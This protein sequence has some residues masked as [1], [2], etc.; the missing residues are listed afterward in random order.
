M[1][2]RKQLPP[3]VELWRDR[4]GKLRAYFRKDRGTRIALPL[5]IGSPE[6]DVAYREALVGGPLV[7]AE[8]IR[9]RGGPG[10][11]ETLIRSYIGS[12]EFR[13]L[14]ATTKAG[15]R[16]QLES[17]RREHGHR[18]VSGLDRERI[19]KL[20]AP[21]A[22][23]PGAALSRL[24]MIRLLIKHA[25]SLGWLVHDPSLGIKR[26]KGSEIRSWTER[27]IAQFEAHWPVGT[28][29]RLGYGLMLFTGQRRSDVHRMV[30]G[31]VADGSIRVTQQKTG[32]KL[33]IPLHP[34]LRAILDAT[35][36]EHVAILFNRRGR[37]FTAHGF[38]VWMRE[39]ISAAG[40]PLDCQPHGLRKAAAR[41]LAEAGCS[42]N[43]IM[44]VT[45]HKSLSEAERYTREA[46]QVRLA[47]AAVA[48]LQRPR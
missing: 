25:I 19:G 8:N 15:Y 43:E 24:K 4:H 18:T 47:T 46:D 34:E 10:T 11:M 28:K 2:R 17:L 1:A 32:A 12:P 39:A 22:G 6:F 29:E 35:E 26:P 3:F 13:S 37:A 14:R 23:K 48:R 9:R 45:G 41:R 33:T 16:F 7:E 40:L 44:A 36:C 5:T 31:D 20:L 30:W 38:S 21:F 27:E 42:A